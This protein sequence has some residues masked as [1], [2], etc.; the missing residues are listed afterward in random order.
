MM[1]GLTLLRA[2]IWIMGLGPMIWLALGF[3]QNTLGANP[4]EALLHVTGRWA[5]A[6][7]LLGLA[8]TP[9]RRLTGWNQIIKVRRTVGLFAFAYATQHLLIY[10]VVDQG[11]AWFFIVEDVLE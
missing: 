2:G 10:L 6:L 4:I 1:S 7:L 3:F 9:L 8:I 5:L 11:L